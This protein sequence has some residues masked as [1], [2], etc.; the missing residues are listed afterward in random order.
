MTP[1][2]SQLNLN[3]GLPV[4]ALGVPRPARTAAAP[5]WYGATPGPADAQ[6]PATRVWDPPWMSSVGPN[7]PP[8]LPP[9]KLLPDPGFR[10][11]ATLGE[12]KGMPHRAVA[13]SLIRETSN[14][15]R[16]EGVGYRARVEP[17]KLAD[18]TCGSPAPG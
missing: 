3:Q 8:W 11:K 13:S 10:A 9:R 16:L 6:S 7:A 14:G 18:E 1:H 4:W 17:E 15:S 5:A 12:G 2:I